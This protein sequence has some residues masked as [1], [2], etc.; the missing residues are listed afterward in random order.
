MN[1]GNL[2]AVSNLVE[3]NNNPIERKT[4]NTMGTAGSIAFGF[5][6]GATL[7]RPP[8][9]K[10]IVSLN[11]LK[12]PECIQCINLDMQKE[13]V[14]LC[15]NRS[16]DL[17]KIRNLNKINKMSLFAENWNGSGGMKF[18]DKSIY[19]FEEI[20]KTLYKQPDIAPTGRNSLL[21]QYALD[22]KSLL[23]FEVSEKRAE[24]VYVPKGDYSLAQTE[25]YTENIIQQ[26]NESVELFY[27]IR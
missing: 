5:F 8:V 27:G 23:A 14:G 9:G 10:D 13:V 7:F 16:I 2:V 1:N 22:D 18:S 17:L 3:K 24:K 12:Q 20:I 21:M 4:F 26:I 19:L 15:T 25:V 11:N 6:V